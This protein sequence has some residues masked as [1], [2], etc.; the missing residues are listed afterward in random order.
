MYDLAAL[1]Q[2]FHC[3]PHINH[4]ATGGNH[5]FIGRQGE[6]VIPLEVTK[7]VSPIKCDKLLQAFA[8]PDLNVYIRIQKGKLQLR[9]GER[10][11]DW[12]NKEANATPPMGTIALVHEPDGKILVVSSLGI[13][14]ATKIGPDLALAVED[15]P[16]RFGRTL[17]DFLMNPSGT[18]QIVLSRQIQLTDAEKRDA[19]NLMKQAYQKHQEQQSEKTEP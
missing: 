3:L 5:G 13:F 18:M 19:I 14:S 12:K 11:D 2:V 17:D 4:T 16:R 9:V 15:A 7:A 6:N 10:R 1:L 8:L